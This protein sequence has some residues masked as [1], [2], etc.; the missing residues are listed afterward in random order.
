MAQHMKTSKKNRQQLYLPK[1]NNRWKWMAGA[2]AA[3]LTASQAG[4]ITITLVNDYISARGRN[5]LNADLTGDGH[6]DLTIANAFNTVSATPNYYFGQL[7]ARVNLNGVLAS[8]NRFNDAFPYWGD[9]QLGSRG[10]GFYRDYYSFPSYVR[11]T[12]DLTGRYPYSSR[13]CTLMMACRLGGCCK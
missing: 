13:I 3:G 10:A 9:E 2:T 5:H 7:H 4:A 12:Y 6:P 1:T 11:G 8:A